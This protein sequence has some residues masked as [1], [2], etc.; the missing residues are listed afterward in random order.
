MARIQPTPEADGTAGATGRRKAVR[1]AV[2]VVVAG[3]AAS[4]IGIGSALASSGAPDL[5]KISAQDLIAKMAASD[6]RQMSGTVKISTDLGL[7]ALPSGLSLGG[8]AKGGGGKGG[9]A[10]PQ[11]KLTELASGTHTLRVA[12]DGPDKQRLSVV[13]QSAEYSV[14]RNGD[15]V[16][17][18]DS[19]SNTAYHSKAQ[20]G[21]HGG[22][23][24]REGMPGDVKDASPQEL[25][26]KALAAAD[27]TTAVTVDG[28]AKVAGR[29]TYQLL[30]K[31]KQSETTVGSIRIAV[32]AK[33]GV[34]LKFT[35]SP[36]SGGKAVV[37]ASFT[38]VDFGKPAADTFSFTP[39]KGAKVTE[40]G[41]E[42]GK[43]AKGGRLPEGLDGLTGGAGHEGGSKVIGKG[44]ASI[45]EFKGDKA[46]VPGKGRSQG[47]DKNAG[48]N[49]DASKLLDSFGSKVTGDFGSGRVF[50]TR[51]VNA[52]MTDD[53]R[54]YVGAVSKDALIKAADAA[55]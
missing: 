48:K 42:V 16:W 45:A 26:K 13:E 9:D 6:T 32:D 5:P 37:D 14:V 19:A 35:L 34:P 2:P 51:I 15:Q 44:W 31:P 17:A 38:K 8:G 20:Q 1:Y 40:G 22:S 53:G 54:V 12:S 11:A 50:S 29:D 25:A 21:Q 27:D 10:S 47:A 24:S 33:N 46:A 3:V 39:P 23:N 36:K 4:A 43:E 7:P 52:L 49:G 55:K 28:T 30:I 18:Y 41:K